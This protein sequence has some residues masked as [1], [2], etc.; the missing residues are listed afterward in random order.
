MKSF[1]TTGPVNCNRHYKLDPL[2]RWDF[3]E[4]LILIDQAK[5]FG[6]CAPRQTGKTTCML[7]LHNYLNEAGDY[8]AIYVN[9]E[10]AR[11]V[12][13]DCD[14][15]IAAVVN[16]L[17]KSVD[18]DVQQARLIQIAEKCDCY[19]AL[20]AALAYLSECSEKPVVLLIDELDSL[21][22]ETFN[23]VLRQIRASYHERPK[24][25]PVSMFLCGVRDIKDYRI[26]VTPLYLE[27]FS[28]DDV[29]KLLTEHTKETDQ[30]FEDSVFDYIFDQTDG[31]PWLVNAIAFDLTSE[32]KESKDHSVV[33][34]KNMA[35][36]AVQ[37]LIASN[38]THLLQLMNKLQEPRVRRL[39]LPMIRGE[40]V[41]P[42]H[43]D[44]DYCIDFG[45]IKRGSR[46]LV[47]ANPIYKE[48]MQSE[49][50]GILC[51]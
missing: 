27:N 25:F 29:Q 7:A 23:T 28:R 4:L 2:H 19:N 50:S 26:K 32:M 6:L 51:K 36:I 43:D 17:S 24:R 8:K 20:S 42:Q 3:E 1:S 5:Y 16:L 31:Q 22:G 18:N 21:V 47:I 46:G 12:G 37:R 48:I 35:E 11:T 13:N 44:R 34:T 9:I 38:N 10:T 39:L 14:R 15:G 33:I 30:K 41:M 49:R 45:L 40:A